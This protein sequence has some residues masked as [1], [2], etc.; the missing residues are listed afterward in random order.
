MPKFRKK[1]VVIDA[2]QWDGSLDGA[3]HIVQEF[4]GNVNYTFL[5]DLSKPPEVSLFCDTLEGRMYASPSDWII[6]GV[7]GEVY[8]CKPDIFDVT[9]EPEE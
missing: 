3:I 7:A 9:Y 1:P 8:P 2:I 5:R 6:H 4:G